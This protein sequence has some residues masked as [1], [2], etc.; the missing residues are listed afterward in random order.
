MPHMQKQIN[1]WEFLHL[2]KNIQI[3]FVQCICIFLGIKREN[4]YCDRKMNI[5]GAEREFNQISYADN[6]TKYIIKV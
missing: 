2:V 1:N 6:I 5:G 4:I 3:S